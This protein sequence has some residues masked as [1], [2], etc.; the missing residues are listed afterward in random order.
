MMEKAQHQDAPTENGVRQM[1]DPSDLSVAQ[2]RSLHPATDSASDNEASERPVREKLKKTSIASIP[3]SG[4]NSLRNDSSME[5]DTI[6]P[7]QHTEDN[8]SRNQDAVQAGAESRGR[9]Q[10]K[11]SF[12][13]LEAQEDT[14]SDRPLKEQSGHH[15]RKRSRDI[16][17]GDDM[18][19][20]ERLKAPGHIPVLEENEDEVNVAGKEMS[21]SR[22]QNAEEATQDLSR[23][24]LQDNN[25]QEMRDS[26]LSPRK[27]RSRDQLDSETHREQKIPATEEAKAHRRSEESEREGIAYNGSIADHAKAQPAQEQQLN[28]LSHN[29]NDLYVSLSIPVVF[30][31]CHYSFGSRNHLRLKL[32]KIHH[33][34]RPT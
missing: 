6:L 34:F 8:T 4:I 28:S 2:N 16:G 19:E 25:D 24:S 31:L 17:V 1:G 27:K 26:A 23:S 9:S 29:A 14:S 5:P 33:T 3:K 15:S 20:H 10:R 22:D 18:E 11:R 12:E 30:N 7:Y 21:G 13:D 32:R